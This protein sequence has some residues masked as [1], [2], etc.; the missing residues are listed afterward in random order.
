MKKITIKVKPNN[1][2]MT[3]E[4]LQNY[5]KTVRNGISVTKNKKGQIERRK[6]YK[7]RF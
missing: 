1:K 7:R 2:K 4:E 6:K 3:A 5:L